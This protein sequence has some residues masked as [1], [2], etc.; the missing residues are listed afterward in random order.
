MDQESRLLKVLGPRVDVGCL[1]NSTLKKREPNFANT[2]FAC[3]VRTMVA[4]SYRV[5]NTSN[6]YTMD[7]TVYYTHVVH[8]T[9]SSRSAIT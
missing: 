1:H 7:D 8:I 5:L 3:L 4:S 9:Y 2:F 6:I